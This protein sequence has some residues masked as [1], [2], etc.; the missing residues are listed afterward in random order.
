MLGA[1]QAAWFADTFGKMA[2]N[3]SLAV[4]GKPN[5]VRLALTCLLSDGHLLLEDNQDLCSSPPHLLDYRADQY[6]LQPWLRLLLPEHRPGPQ[7]RQPAAPDHALQAHLGDDH[8]ILEFARQRMAAAGL[9]GCTILLFGGEPLLNPRGC[10]ELL[11][12]PPTTA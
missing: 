2:D 6:R 7:G 11:R 3:V 10:V 4:L 9:E 8:A 1:D 5:V 12:G